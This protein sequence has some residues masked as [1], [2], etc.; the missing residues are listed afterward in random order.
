M[1]PA[2][3]FVALAFSDGGTCVAA[4]S[5]GVLEKLR[6]TDVPA[7]GQTT[8]LLDLVDVIT[9]VSGGSYTAACHGLFGDRIFDDFRSRFL[10]RNRQGELLRLLRRPDHLLSIASGH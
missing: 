9:T 4:F 10:Y 8:R 3:P 5:Y 2:I 7:C 1:F 6:D